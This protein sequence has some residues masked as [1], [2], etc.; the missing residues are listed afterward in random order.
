VIGC[1]LG[2]DPARVSAGNF[3]FARTIDEAVRQA[4]LAVGGNAGSSQASQP[5]ENEQILA[6][7]MATRLP[8]QKYLA[9]HP[10]R[11][12]FC[13]Q[14]QQILREAGCGCIPTAQSIQKTGSSILTGV[15]GTALWIWG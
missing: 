6:Q 14:S 2:V 5:D 1:F 8:E 4:I 11:R 7:E 12:T 10:G 3:Q 15:A 13:Y 9:R